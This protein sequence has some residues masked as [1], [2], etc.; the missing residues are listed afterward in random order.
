[1]PI[2]GSAKAVLAGTVVLLALAAPAQAQGVQTSPNQVPTAPDGTPPGT[3]LSD[4]L[5]ESNGVLRPPAGIDPQIQTPAPE[6]N[7]QTTPVIPPP[8]TP[9]GDRSVEPK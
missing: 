2:N 5:S 6:P 7:P 1:M 9:G 3:T 4:R 8:G